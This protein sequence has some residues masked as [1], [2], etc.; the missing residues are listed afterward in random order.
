MPVPN[1]IV[2]CVSNERI[3]RD[4]YE[5]RFQ[6]PAGMNFKSG[7]FILF[8]VPLIEKTDDIQT[9]ALSIA[10]APSENDLLFVA[11]MKEGGRVSRW[12]EEVLTPGTRARMQG[13]FGNFTIKEEDATRDLLMIATSTGVAPFR[14]HIMEL[15]E[16]CDVILR[17]SAERHEGRIDLVF[18]VRSEEDLFW[19]V[20]LEQLAQ[21][22]ENFFLHFALSNPTDGWS[23][24]RGRVQTLVPLIAQDISTRTVFVCGSPDMTK[25]VKSLA[26]TEWNVPKERLH[27]EGYI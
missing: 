23:G 8:D 4:V 11:K 3:A 5:F 19:K 25:E 15:A 24:H 21:K 7:Q 18:G 17:S 22:T 6:K 10:S 14:S 9:R 20:E 16:K 27:V 12:I 13:P 26:L 2:E 1:Y